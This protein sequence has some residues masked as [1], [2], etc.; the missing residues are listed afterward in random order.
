MVA[1]ILAIIANIFAI[2]N[3]TDLTIATIAL[4]IASATFAINFYVL[5]LFLA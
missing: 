1:L 3:K 5:I 2:K 4:A